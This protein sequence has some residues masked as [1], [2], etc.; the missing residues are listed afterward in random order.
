[1]PKTAVYLF[2]ALLLLFA[3][4]S[5]VSAQLSSSGIAISTPVADANAQDG[6]IICT[7]ETGNVRC[8]REYDTSIYGVISDNPAAAVE[9]EELE[10]ARLVISSGVA[11]VR[12]SSLN[13]NITEGDF[14]TTSE[15]AGIGMRADRNG[16][17]LGMALETY[18]SGD[19]E[20][21]GRIQV[22]VNIHPTGSL[23]GS[24]GN[25]LQFIREGLAVPIF[26]PVESLRYILAV[27]I[28]LISFT[29]GM[30]YF[31]R[32]S[33][34]GIEA[35]GRNPLA[36][37]VIQLTVVM[38]ITLTIVIVLVGLGLAYLILIF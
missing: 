28:V 23:T 34:A 26:D 2:T 5:P 17:V 19:T 3:G 7:Y 30:I 18:E 24:R 21:I 9:D 6:D 1:M 37:R 16:Y 33:R 15:R 20:A 36:K 8:D 25:L 22:M 29:L 10:N 38:N 35:I 31:G 12:V 14:V 32:A 13:G 4:V 11:T 27:A